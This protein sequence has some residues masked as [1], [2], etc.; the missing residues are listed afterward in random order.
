MWSTL[1]G[2]ELQRT[3]FD[4]CSISGGER[5]VI[6]SG[7]IVHIRVKAPHHLVIERGSKFT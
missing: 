3:F 1:P 6:V 4:S 5:T 7:D 2:L